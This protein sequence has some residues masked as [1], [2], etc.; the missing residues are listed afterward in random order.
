MIKVVTFSARKGGVGK[1]LLTASMAVLASQQAPTAIIDLDP[2]GCLTAWFD[3]RSLREPILAEVRPETLQ[4]APG[5]MA[6]RGCEWLFID[7]PPGFGD[8]V[9]E[10]MVLADLVVVPTKPGELDIEATLKTVAMA[11]ALDVAYAVLPNDATFRS[12]AMGEAINYYRDAGLPLLSAVHHRVNL[13][14]RKGL[15]LPERS[16][17]CTGSRELNRAWQELQALVGGGVSA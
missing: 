4:Q 5:E 9:A 8:I 12:R 1:T 3:R 14:L 15:A 13:M 16:P 17:N 6:A 2:Q 7:T 10:A 11:E